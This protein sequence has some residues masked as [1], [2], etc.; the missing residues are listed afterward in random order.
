MIVWCNTPLASTHFIYISLK[1]TC[2]HAYPTTS[3]VYP[4]NEPR[5]TYQ[6]CRSPQNDIARSTDSSA[7][8]AAEGGKKQLHGSY[9]KSIHRQQAY[10]LFVLTV[11]YGSP[12]PPSSKE[13]QNN[14]LV[15]RRSSLLLRSIPDPKKF[16][17]NGP[18]RD[19]NAGPPAGLSEEPK[20]GI[21]PLAA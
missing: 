3:T 8:S 11:Q 14:N 7:T 10:C 4:V 16:K 17:K 20:A 1:T 12:R 9:R 18:H 2:M 19:S 5:H 15:G 21:I 6:V 13:S